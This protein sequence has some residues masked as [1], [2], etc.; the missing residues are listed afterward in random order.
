M[1]YVLRPEERPGDGLARVIR[2]QAG[3]LAAE[4]EQAGDKPERFVHGARVRAK[5]I[6]AALQLARPLMAAHDYKRENTWWRDAA[7]GISEARDHNARLEALDALAPFI[8]AEVGA[9]AVMRMRA[10]FLR[11]RATFAREKGAVEAIATFCATLKERGTGAPRIEMGDRNAVIEGYGQS[12]R[13]ARRS[14]KDAFK[15]R[16]AEALHEWRK[17]VKRHA[18]QTKLVRGLFNGLDERVEAAGEL[19]ALLG[20]LQDLE[21]LVQAL[22]TGELGEEDRA[23]I[24]VLEGRRVVM[25]TSARAS[26]ELLFAD[27]RRKWV[28]ALRGEAVA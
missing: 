25:T 28:G 10:R 3:K 18:L 6:R 15:D 26:G 1:A 22:D 12:Y 23:V 7:R 24:A 2:E 9:A 20:D 19:A 14:M 16:T 17:A 11:D 8:E 21:I 13:D 4:C 27:K 5:K